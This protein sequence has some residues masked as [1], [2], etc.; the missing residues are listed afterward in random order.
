[1]GAGGSMFTQ[2][3]QNPGQPPD[4]VQ[5]GIGA[6]FGAIGGGITAGLITKGAPAVATAASKWWGQGIIGGFT[7]AGAGAAEGLYTGAKT[8]LTGD[9]YRQHVQDSTLSGLI[10]G[11]IFGAIGGAIGQGANKFT[12]SDVAPAPP[13]PEPPALPAPRTTPALEAPPQLR[14]SRPPLRSRCSSHH[15]AIYCPSLGQVSL[16]L[17]PRKHQGLLPLATRFPPGG[18]YANPDWQFPHQETQSSRHPLQSTTD[19]SPK[20]GSHQNLDCS[21]NHEIERTERGA[22]THGTRTRKINSSL[23]EILEGARTAENPF[24]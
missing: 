24:H 12:G 5:V 7:G 23:A 22:V 4:L 3:L 16:Y 15:Q 18:E 13:T 1:M 21:P 6:A 17:S 2:G 8:G 20:A 10:N 9:A 19:P 11:A 14:C